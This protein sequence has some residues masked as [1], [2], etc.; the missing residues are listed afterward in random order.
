MSTARKLTAYAAALAAV[1]G[2]SVVVGGA[3]DPTGLATAEPA[4]DHRGMA[5][6]MALPGLAIAEDGLRLVPATDTHPLGD[7][8][9]YRFQVVDG[10]G[11]VTDFDVQH[12][13]RMHLIVVRR[14]FAGFQH[15][16]PTMTPDGTWQVPVELDDAGT[17]RVFADFAVDGDKHTLGADLFVPGTADP[18]PLPAEDH[19]ADAGDG[20]TVELQGEPAAGTESELTF[21]VR[22]DGVAVT[23]L[24]PYLGALGHLVA[25]RDG[26]LAYLH[27]H[28]DRERLAFEADFPSVGAYRLFLQ[29]QHRGE[30]HTAAFTVDA[31]ESR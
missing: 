19:V 16:H 30:V 31:E 9:P 28:A 29:F 1:F 14:D 20:Y 10:D 11:P 13:K 25:L 8:S 4:A 23:D 12:T 2:A 27:V 15:L 22:H 3:V 24:E 7:E 5:A 21:V 26:D 6:G 17:Y 18:R